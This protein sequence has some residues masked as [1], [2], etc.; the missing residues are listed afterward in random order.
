MSLFAQYTGN[1]SIVACV[2]RLRGFMAQHVVSGNN[3]LTSRREDSAVSWAVDSECVQVVT[4]G[5]SCPA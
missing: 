4:P 1:L 2:L 5:H 3:I